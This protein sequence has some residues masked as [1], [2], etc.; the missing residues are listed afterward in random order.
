MVN[1]TYFDVLTHLGQFP[2]SKHSARL[3]W[4]KQLFDAI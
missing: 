2:S 4:L 3:L 1:V